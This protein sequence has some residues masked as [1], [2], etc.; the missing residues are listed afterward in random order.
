ML[1]DAESEGSEAGSVHRDDAVLL[2]PRPPQG[3]TVW[4]ALD[5]H[6]LTSA[7]LDAFLQPLGPNALGNARFNNKQPLPTHH[8]YETAQVFVK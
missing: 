3:R 8:Q 4:Q 1:S 7:Q 5:V 2:M 6:G